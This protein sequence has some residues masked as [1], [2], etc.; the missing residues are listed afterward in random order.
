M[1][2]QEALSLQWNTQFTTQGQT[3]PAEVF[4]NGDGTGIYNLNDGSQGTLF[5]MS[6]IPATNAPGV[7][8]SAGTYVGSWALNGQSG[9][10]EW[11]VFTLNFTEFNGR[12]LNSATGESGGWSG[13]RTPA[14]LSPI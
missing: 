13:F 3:I 6:F 8:A 7:P 10:L 2:P 14:P 4:L 5:Q 1:T 11:N 9:S 12:F